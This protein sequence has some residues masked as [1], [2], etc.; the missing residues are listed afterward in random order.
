MW[1][2][3]KS[4]QFNKRNNSSNNDVDENIPINETQVGSQNSGPNSA[5][6][7]FCWNKINN[8]TELWEANLRSGGQLTGAAG[9][10]SGVGVSNS[11]QEKQKK[12]APYHPLTNLGGIWGENELEH[13]MDMEFNNME[14]NPHQNVLNFNNENNGDEEENVFLRKKHRNLDSF[15]GY[16]HEF[17]SSNNANSTPSAVAG[18]GN[19][20]SNSAAVGAVSV[21][22]NSSTANTSSNES[23]IRGDPRGISGRLN[24]NPELW[25]QNPQSFSQNSNFFNQNYPNKNQVFQNQSNFINF[26]QID[27]NQSLDFGT[28]LNQPN[29]QFNPTTNS[30]QKRNSSI[31][32]GG[33]G[34]LGSGGGGAGF[35][36]FVDDLGTSIWGFNAQNPPNINQNSANVVNQNFSSL[37]NQN[38]INQKRVGTTVAG[39]GVVTGGS[40]M[41]NN[42]VSANWGDIDKVPTGITGAGGWTKFMN[43]DKPT[44]TPWPAAA[45]PNQSGTGGSNQNGSNVPQQ[46]SNIQI[47]QSQNLVNTPKFENPVDIVDWKNSQKNFN[48]PNQELFH[49]NSL[50]QNT[51]KSFLPF[52]YPIKNNQN[53]RYLNS[54]NS[55]ELLFSAPGTA[56]TS[57]NA[58]SANPVG[59]KGGKLDDFSTPCDAFGSTLPDDFM[60]YNKNQNA[61]FSQSNTPGSNFNFN[62]KQNLSAMHFNQHEFNSSTG[63]NPSVGSSLPNTG[64]DSVDRIVRGNNGASGFHHQN[65]NN[66]QMPQSPPI[67]IENAN[68]I[69]LERMGNAPGLQSVG[70]QPPPNH[71]LHSQQQNQ[72]GNFQQNHVKILYNFLL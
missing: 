50:S 48:I 69:L 35:N 56:P 15:D 14:N 31:S 65:P 24:G 36:N 13:D 72:R 40:G 68:R 44:G 42:P 3:P 32:G 27:K 37:R 53:Q 20:S 33:N 23:V 61:P 19:N 21:G 58:T 39:N 49:P 26:P 47:S 30:A 25:N 11:T 60:M 28:P 6:L 1:D 66:Q 63:G 43:N 9:G 55:N 4:P 54:G 52:P 10:S 7:Q 59:N 71:P 38:Q 34:N 29:S 46:N 16:H 62:Q 70:T 2:L 64:N 67:S 57:S 51:Q 8:G 18:V 5:K 12:P 17:L 41:V 22:I 45:A